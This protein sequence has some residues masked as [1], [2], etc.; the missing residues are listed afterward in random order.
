[1]ECYN[2]ALVNK[3]LDERDKI[4]EEDR[5][6]DSLARDDAEHRLLLDYKSDEYTKI[7]DFIYDNTFFHNQ[8][9][10]FINSV[11]KS[12]SV[13]SIENFQKFI[14][15]MAYETARKEIKKSWEDNSNE[16]NRVLRQPH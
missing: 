3:Y 4:V 11:I 16:T 13:E 9:D 7:F 8:F 12:A 10:K 14:R 1:M 5:L 2:T 15:E 6:L